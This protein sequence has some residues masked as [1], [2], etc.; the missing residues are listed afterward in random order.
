MPPA[1]RVFT[2]PAWVEGSLT[3]KPF[4]LRDRDVLHIERDAVTTL[5]IAGPEG[6]Y[7]LAKDEKGEWAIVRPLRTR[8][9]RWSVDAL[10]GLLAA[11]RMDEVAAENAADPRA[12]GLAPPARTVTIGLSDG[13]TRKLEVGS[14]PSEGR[15]HVRVAGSPL[16]AVVPGALAGDLAKGMGELRAKRLLEVSTYEVEG[17]DVE[18]GGVKRVLARTSSKNEQGTDVHKWKRTAPDAKDLDTNK[19]QDALFAVGGLEVLEFIDSP[20]GL[21]AYGLD[22]PALRVSLRHTGGRAPAWFEIGTKDGGS[23]A[24]RDGD[25][26]VMKLDPVKTAELIKGFAEL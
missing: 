17:L 1:P 8:A 25:A 26:A 20:A 13:T 11:L 6:A 14:S 22:A 12:F 15:H 7:A 19:V 16:V 21:P 4:D 24:R 2:V 23:Y 5:D 3:K 18:A 10:V 9:G